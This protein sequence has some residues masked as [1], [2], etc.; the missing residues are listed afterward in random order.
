MRLWRTALVG[1]V[2]LALTG[3]GA[4]QAV[5]VAPVR[6][7]DWR[8]AVAD[9]VAEYGHR[10]W[11][12]IADAAYPAQVR[13]GIE[14]LPAHADHLKVVAAVLDELGKAKHVR[15]VV[16]TDAELPH[17]AERDAAGVIEF[18]RELKALLADRKP[19]A[20]PHEQ[21]IDRI[22]KAAERYKVLVL[23]TDL[24]LPYTSVFVELDSGYWTPEA[25]KRLREAMNAGKKEKERN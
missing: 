1:V 8:E 21:M 15:P 7:Y 3:T 9:R 4:G 18:R 24:M 6:P 13:P 17:V 2:C 11:I 25:E 22:D 16:Y 5:R 14:M 20:V 19:Q 23:K 12:V 10:N